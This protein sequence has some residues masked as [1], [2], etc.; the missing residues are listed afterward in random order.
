MLLLDIFSFPDDDNDNNFTRSFLLGLTEVMH[1]LFK[2]KG[3]GPWGSRGSLQTKT[4]LFFCLPT[5]LEELH[6]KSP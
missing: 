3:G 6:P 5:S 4:K 2:K 1:F